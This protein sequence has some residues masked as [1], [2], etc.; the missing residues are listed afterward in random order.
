MVGLEGDDGPPEERRSWMVL[1]SI[2][3][4]CFLIG[5][6]FLL[7]AVWLDWD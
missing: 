3:T 6:G 7:L 2:I 4:V 5:I 1:V